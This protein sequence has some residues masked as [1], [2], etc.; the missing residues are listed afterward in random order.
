[1][2][3]TSSLTSGGST[4]EVVLYANNWDSMLVLGW[5]RGKRPFTSSCGLHKSY[6]LCMLLREIRKCLEAENP[7]N[8]SGKVRP[9]LSLQKYTPFLLHL[10]IV[11]VSM[12]FESRVW[13]L[14]CSFFNSR[15]HLHCSSAE[16]IP[17]YITGIICHSVIFHLLLPS[18]E[19]PAGWGDWSTEEYNHTGMAEKGWACLFMSNTEP[20][21]E[22][23]H[24][25]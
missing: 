10:N 7:V 9:R 4:Y 25:Q 5:A 20:M 15:L 13:I 8:R 2:T 18:A 21:T 12:E 6:L 16:L 22:R 3:T 24:K 11:K 14:S 1:M 19:S 17:Y 23:S